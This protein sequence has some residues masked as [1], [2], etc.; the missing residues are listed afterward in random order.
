MSSLLEFDK[1]LRELAD[2]GGDREAPRR[3]FATPLLNVPPPK[4]LQASFMTAW[5]KARPRT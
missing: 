4:D 2:F 1:G 5:A 3:P